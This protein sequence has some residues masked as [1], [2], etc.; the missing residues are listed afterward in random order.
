MVYLFSFVIIEQVLLLRVSIQA[1]CSHWADVICAVIW[2]LRS[3]VEREKTKMSI[4][5]EGINVLS[6]LEC[7]VLPLL[8]RDE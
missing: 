5:P 4:F 3:Y 8:L 7:T 2:E 1:L 6:L